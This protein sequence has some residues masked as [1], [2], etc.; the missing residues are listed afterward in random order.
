MNSP[1]IGSY[2]VIG[3]GNGSQ[4]AYVSGIA[5]TGALQIQRCQAWRSTNHN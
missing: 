3:F 4:L 2:L 1:T 5:R